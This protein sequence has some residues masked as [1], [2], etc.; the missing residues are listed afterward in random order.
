LNDPRPGG[1]AAPKEREGWGLHQEWYQ[2]LF[3]SQVE[4]GK[5]IKKYSDTRSGIRANAELISVG[6]GDRVRYS[7]EVVARCATDDKQPGGL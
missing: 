5:E 2:S 1:R 4:K 3:F 7:V 6:K